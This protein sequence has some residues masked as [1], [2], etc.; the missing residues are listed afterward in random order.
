MVTQEYNCGSIQVLF[1]TSS[2]T[3]PTDDISN[4]SV[5]IEVDTGKKFRFDE[6]NL[7][8]YDF[9]YVKVVF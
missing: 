9:G 2:D 6:E 4:G 3:K 5:I 8:W 7:T 1:L